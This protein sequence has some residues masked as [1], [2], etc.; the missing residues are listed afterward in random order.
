M[1]WDAKTHLTWCP[2]LTTGGSG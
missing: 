1:S 2:R